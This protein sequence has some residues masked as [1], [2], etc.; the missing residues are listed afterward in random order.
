[1]KEAFAR[2]RRNRHIVEASFVSRS[3][4]NQQTDLIESTRIYSIDSQAGAPPA[5]TAAAIQRLLVLGPTVTPAEEAAALAALTASVSPMPSQA[6]QRS[7][8]PLHVEAAAPAQEPPLEQEEE[9][10][11]SP[12]LI[13]PPPGPHPQPDDVKANDAEPMDRG[14]ESAAAAT[15]NAPAPASE[16]DEGKEE[17]EAAAAAAAQPPPL[18]PP[19]PETPSTLAE[20]GPIWMMQI[21]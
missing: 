14:V 2:L 4:L 5:A 21:K 20:L 12:L 9:E 7:P 16:E 17:E 11:P 3:A 8:Q 13:P 19:P 6:S 1:M 10:D 15:I 18:P